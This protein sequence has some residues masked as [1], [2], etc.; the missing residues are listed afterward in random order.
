MR[1]NI[2]RLLLPSAR[3]LLGQATASS[4]RQAYVRKSAGQGA[5]KLPAANTPT[6][7]QVTT[8]TKGGTA[9]HAATKPAPPGATNSPNPPS[10][11]GPKPPEGVKAATNEIKAG[12]PLG[13][14]PLA[15]PPGSAPPVPPTGAAAGGGAPKPPTKWVTPF[16]LLAAPVAAYLSYEYYLKGILGP[17]PVIV[18]DDV[19]YM[20]D[21]DIY[22]ASPDAADK[23]AAAGQ[24]HATAGF[25]EAFS[26]RTLQPG[27]QE[28]CVAVA[29]C[30]QLLHNDNQQ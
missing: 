24:H 21:E 12:H 7:Q 4:G 2:Q 6:K 10:P 16:V 8:A 28:V 9:S 15:S 23:D 29:E 5:T 17:G 13:V 26:M 14:V 11:V 20:P 22:K 30:V 19:A 18:G 3:R 25:R 27:E 1:S